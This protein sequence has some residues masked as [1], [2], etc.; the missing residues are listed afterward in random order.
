MF[1]DPDWNAVN[2]N[3]HQFNSK[4]WRDLQKEAEEKLN[5][6][7]QE[8]HQVSVD[9]D[10]RIPDKMRY[11]FDVKIREAEGTGYSYTYR[12]L[13]GVFWGALDVREIRYISSVSYF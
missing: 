4:K 11:P 8:G 7:R 5:Q 10:A 3:V 13:N 12:G 2:T 6:A 9:K 1:P